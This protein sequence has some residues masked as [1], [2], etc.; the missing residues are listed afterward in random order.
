MSTKYEVITYED[1][2]VFNYTL[3]GEESV[4]QISRDVTLVWEDTI[5]KFFEAHTPE[6]P[7]TIHSFERERDKEKFIAD[8]ENQTEEMIDAVD[9]EIG[10]RMKFGHF[11]TSPTYED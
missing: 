11:Y 7:Y 3:P 2:I 9:E 5:E 8:I 4:E 10:Q 6:K 1:V